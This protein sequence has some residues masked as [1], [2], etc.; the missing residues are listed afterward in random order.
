MASRLTGATSSGFPFLKLIQP[1]AVSRHGHRIAYG[2]PRPSVTC[3]ARSSSNGAFSIG[4]QSSSHTSPEA[5]AFGLSTIQS[6]ECLV[7]TRNHNFSSSRRLGWSKPPGCSSAKGS[8]PDFGL[9]TPRT[10]PWGTGAMGIG[11]DR[12]AAPR[13]I[14]SRWRM[15]SECESS[16]IAFAQRSICCTRSAGSR[17]DFTWRWTAFGRPVFLRTT[18]F[19]FA[20]A[21]CPRR[22]WQEAGNTDSPSQT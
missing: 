2:A 22:R 4:F 8:I 6:D 1:V 3:T 14:S 9:A 16:P 15:A 20:R 12:S 11:G 7:G 18:D 10:S 19:D 5:A 21:R 13:P 17:S